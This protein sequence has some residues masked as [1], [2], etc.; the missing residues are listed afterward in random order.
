MSRAEQIFGTNR[1][2]PCMYLRYSSPNFSANLLPHFIFLCILVFLVASEFCDMKRPVNFS[3]ALRVSA[4]S[5]FQKSRSLARIPLFSAWIGMSS[6]TFLFARKVLNAEVA[7]G[8][9]DSVYRIDRT[10]SSRQIR[11]QP[12]APPVIY[13]Q[14]CS[15]Y[16][17][18]SVLKPRPSS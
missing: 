15:F 4:D 11:A 14:F 13:R 12:V 5:A 2:V 17:G 7:E 18:S 16:C 8:R 9:R 3:A 6:C 1:P 10:L